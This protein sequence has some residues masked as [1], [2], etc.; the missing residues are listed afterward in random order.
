MLCPSVG[1][2]HDSQPWLSLLLGCAAIWFNVLNTPSRV[3]GWWSAPA[4]RSVVVEHH[5]LNHASSVMLK[6]CAQSIFIHLPCISPSMPL[7]LCCSRRHLYSIPSAA[8]PGDMCYFPLHYYVSDV[9][10]TFLNWLLPDPF[11]LSASFL[12][13]KSFY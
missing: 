13:W 11:S 5:F 4:H 3:E 2:G 9:T 1:E 8:I 6:S 10:N 7:P 12:P